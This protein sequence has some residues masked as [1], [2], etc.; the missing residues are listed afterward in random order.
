M[1]RQKDGQEAHVRM[2]VFRNVVNIT[3]IDYVD[4]RGLMQC[5]Q[6]LGD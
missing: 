3:G 1:E 5:D 4:T 6:L 2:A